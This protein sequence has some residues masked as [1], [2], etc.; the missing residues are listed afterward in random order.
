M[1]STLHQVRA[2]ALHQCSDRKEVLEM[3]V[4]LKLSPLIIAIEICLIAISAALRHVA[5]YRSKEQKG[6]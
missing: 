2:R 3:T 1:E 5:D 6:K 4:T